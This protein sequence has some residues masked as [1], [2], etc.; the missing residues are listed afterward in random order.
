M[1]QLTSDNAERWEQTFRSQP[2]G[3]YPS[4]DIVRFL[5]RTFRGRQKTEPVRVLDLG[6]GPGANLWAIVR[7]GYQTAGIDFSPT[8]I[9]RAAERLV[10]EGLAPADLKLGDF[11]VLPWPDHS[12]DAVIDDDSL[13]TNHWDTIQA[14]IAEIRRVLKPGGWFAAKLLGAATTG[15]GSGRPVDD[16]GSEWDPTEGVI[17]G[18]GL[19]HCFT[20]AEIPALLADFADV[21]IGSTQR[22]DLESGWDVFYWVFKGRKRD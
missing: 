5:A 13:S 6:C 3:R 4:E 16:H 15:A 11:R 7:E 12:F 8:A 22:R 20:E 18:H 19:I 17:A 1:D 2:Y 10:E 14:T 21:R 9:R